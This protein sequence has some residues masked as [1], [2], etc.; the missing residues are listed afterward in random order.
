MATITPDTNTP[1]PIRV[2][3]QSVSPKNNHASKAEKRACVANKTPERRGP[4]R[5]MHTNNAVSPT[6]MPIQLD[7]D[8][9]ATLSHVSSGQ[10]PTYKAPPQSKIMAKN[11]RHRVK[12]KAPIAVDALA[13]NKAPTAQQPEA[14]AA[15]NSGASINCPQP[16]CD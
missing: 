4:N 16:S 3:P 10:R 6:K 2:I 7:T 9:H 12:A 1:L 14:M 8:N 13:E 5:F 11:K 15:N